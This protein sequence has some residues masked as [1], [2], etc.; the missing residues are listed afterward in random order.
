RPGTRFPG[1]TDLAPRGG[2]LYELLVGRQTGE[3]DEPGLLP[4][5]PST[6][7]TGVDPAL[8]RV[9]MQA[10]AFDPRHRPESA[11]AIASQLAA[12][13]AHPTPSRR[14]YWAVAA[15]VLAAVMAGIVLLTPFGRR[16]ADTLSEQD[17]I[18]L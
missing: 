2:V 7:V 10:L 4:P 1:G 8:E 16:G 6:L 12:T 9:V 18:L 5:R 17:T 3:H 13:P 14:P 15:A 11:A